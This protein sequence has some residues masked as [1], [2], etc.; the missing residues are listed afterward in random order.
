MTCQTLVVALAGMVFLLGCSSESAAPARTKAAVQTPTPSPPAV[1]LDAGPAGPV[2]RID[3]AR[4]MQYTREIFALGPRFVGSPG[5]Q[6][7]AAY[8]RAKLKNDNLEEDAFEQETPAGKKPMRNLIAKFTGSREGMI[9]L[10]SHF[11]TNY[12]LRKTSYA[13]ANDGASSTALLLAIADQL[14]GKK[15]EG[16][17]ICLVFLDGEEAVEEW[18]DTDSLYGSRR[19]AARWEKDGTLRK[20]KALLLADMIGDA[21]LNIDQEDRST[22]WLR[23]L[24]LKAATSLGY[25]SH[26]FHR[27]IPID[28]DHMPFVRR[29]VPAIDLIDM[30]YGYGDSYH[31]TVEDTLDKLSPQSLQI[32]GDVILETIRLLNGNASQLPQ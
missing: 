19:L 8:L 17:S 20:I 29:G 22:P 10:A 30:D 26:F 21:D 28:D 11:D 3:A 13:G 1:S 4:A 5:Q 2:L 24:V 18:T 6:K 32:T 15:L 27:Q 7:A 23:A 16:F 12:P 25:Q 14:R 9:V 31:H